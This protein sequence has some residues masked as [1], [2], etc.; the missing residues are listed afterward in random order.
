MSGHQVILEQL[1]ICHVCQQSVKILTLLDRAQVKAPIGPSS[2]PCV[3][4][5]RYILTR[6]HILTCDIF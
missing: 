1:E 2:A 3:E 5:Q 6:L 4:K